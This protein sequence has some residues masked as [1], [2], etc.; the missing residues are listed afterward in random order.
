MQLGEE[1]ERAEE[2]WRETKRERE[3]ERERERSQS[4]DAKGKRRND[5]E[6]T[7]DS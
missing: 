3:R 6:G 7:S 4:A 5:R 2:L 1:N